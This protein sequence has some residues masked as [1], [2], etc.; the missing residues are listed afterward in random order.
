MLVSKIRPL[1]KILSLLSFAFGDLTM[2]YTQPFQN[3]GQSQWKT[4]GTQ[5][6]ILSFICGHFLSSN[7]KQVMLVNVSFSSPTKLLLKFS[8][9]IALYSTLCSTFLSFYPTKTPSVS[10]VSSSGLP[11]PPC[12]MSGSLPWHLSPAVF[13]SRPN[14]VP[15]H[16]C[17]FSAWQLCGQ[18]T[19]HLMTSWHM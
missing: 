1:P 8:L 13:R 11:I 15:G 7:I 3:G 16:S 9:F 19:Q 5:V 10:P 2:S 17:L 4:T 18:Q 12:P 14:A 6:E